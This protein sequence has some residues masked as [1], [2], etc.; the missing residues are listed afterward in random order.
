MTAR[1]SLTLDAVKDAA[2]KALKFAVELEP[3]PERGLVV[4]AARKLIE[5]VDYYRRVEEKRERAT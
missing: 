5:V 2:D 4:F 1:V 3:V